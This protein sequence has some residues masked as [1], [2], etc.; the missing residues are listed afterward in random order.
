MCREREKKDRKSRFVKKEK[1]QSENEYHFLQNVS[2]KGRREEKEKSWTSESEERTIFFH[3]I[4]LRKLCKNSPKNGSRRIPKVLRKKET[5]LNGN[6]ELDRCVNPDPKKIAF[7][8]N[9]EAR[10]LLT[11]LVT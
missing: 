10:K 11:L 4:S 7:H 8:F 2:V 1:W 3:S 9:D 6:V 5:L